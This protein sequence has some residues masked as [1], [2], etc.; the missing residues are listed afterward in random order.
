MRER[1]CDTKLAVA[2]VIPQLL[3][4]DVHLAVIDFEAAIPMVVDVGFALQLVR[5][6]T[7]TSALV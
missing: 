2:T 1:C 3:R 7:S 4:E 6:I 5:E